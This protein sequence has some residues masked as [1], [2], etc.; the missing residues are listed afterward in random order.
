MS[1]G[2]DVG[3][4]V[5][6]VMTSS[7]RCLGLK[8][9]EAWAPWRIVIVGVRCWGWRRRRD[10][11]QSP[12]LGCTREISESSGPRW[13]GGCCRW[14]WRE[15]S[16]CKNCW[17]GGGG[18]TDSREGNKNFRGGCLWTGELS[19]SELSHGRQRGFPAQP[20]AIPPP[21][22]PPAP[23]IPCSIMP[24]ADDAASGVSNPRSRPRTE[25]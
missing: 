22:H 1:S 11:D 8:G 21:T 12:L 19:H 16:G 23:A 18:W 13:I 10:G 4:G 17:R 3:D 24:V 2:R 6:V 14:M 9:K 20:P 5:V 25:C 15:K 7:P